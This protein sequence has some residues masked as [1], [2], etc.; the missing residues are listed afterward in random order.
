MLKFVRILRNQ[1]IDKTMKLKVSTSDVHPYLD[2]A[3]DI[4][5]EMK[6]L[7]EKVLQK[8]QEYKKKLPEKLEHYLLLRSLFSCIG[9][10]GVKLANQYKAAKESS[11]YTTD[12]DTDDERK[13]NELVKNIKNMRLE[14]L[15]HSETVD[16]EK[17]DQ[18]IRNF[19]KSLGFC[20]LDPWVR[21]S[22]LMSIKKNHGISCAEILAVAESDPC[23]QEVTVREY[24]DGDN[25]DSNPPKHNG[26][27]STGQSVKALKIFD[28]TR[29]K[30]PQMYDLS[31]MSSFIHS[32]GGNSDVA[33][34][35]SDIPIFL[36]ESTMEG[37]YI[38]VPEE[39]CS[40]CVPPDK[41]C[42]ISGEKFDIDEWFRSKEDSVRNPNEPTSIVIN[43]LLGVY[44]YNSNNR[45]MPRKIFIWMDKIQKVV[46]EKTK[47][48][49]SRPGNAG[50]LFDLVLYHEL[51]HGLMD[52]E[53]YGKVPASGF[54][55]SDY[56][57]RCIEEAYANAISL[58]TL[59]NKDS[60]LLK[61]A[62]VFIKDFVQNQGPGYED[63]WDLYLNDCV[64]AKELEQWMYAKVLFN[65][66]VAREIRNFWKEYPESIGIKVNN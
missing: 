33:S 36:V 59:E 21:F 3:K 42:S 56:V 11:K 20:V 15:V 44:I 46:D 34:R 53:L 14:S 62:K 9:A 6:S 1:I 64:R 27:A 49:Q 26:K 66:D 35:L 5:K 30:Y 39:G 55:Y 2:D 52:V 29:G 23:P 19:P 58:K 17:L 38:S 45:L 50:A 48:G 4:N 10:L 32:I 54:T 13:L 22:F 43:D 40:V 12:Q 60:Y 16:L 47:A 8:L 7:Q 28:L 57:Y 41:F 31:P 61:T 63:G 18:C 24:L 25:E 65:Y 51:S 37:V